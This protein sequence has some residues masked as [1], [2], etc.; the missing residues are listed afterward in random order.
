MY[1]FSDLDPLL[2]SIKKKRKKNNNNNKKI[3]KMTPLPKEGNSNLRIALHGWILYFE[4]QIL[5]ILNEIKMIIL[6]YFDRGAPFTYPPKE[7]S[8]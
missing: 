4:K 5:S 6:P 1:L 3:K 7:H 2:F 8:E